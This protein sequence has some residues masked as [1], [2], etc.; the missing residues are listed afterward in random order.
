MSE[1]PPD[2]RTDAADASNGPIRVCHV[3][4]EPDFARMVA[5]NLE[6]ETDRF[7]VEWTTDPDDVVEWVADGAVDCVLTDY[8]MGETTGLELLSSLREIDADL[9]V[10]LFTDTGSETVASDAISAGVSDYLIKGTVAEQYAL[11]ANTIR[12]HVERRRASEAA[13]R[14]SRQL[15]EIADNTSDVLWLFSGDWSELLF[16]NSAY[17][18]VFGQSI[19][20]LSADTSAFLQQVHPEDTADLEAAMTA[21]AAGESR[22]IEYR[23]GGETV[24]WVESVAEPIRNDAG[25]VVRIAGFTR[26]ITDRKQWELDLREK[27]ERLER[28]A[29]MV[30]HDLRNPLSVASGYLDLARNAHDSEHLATVARALGRMERLI[31]DLLAL[32]REGQDVTD[33]TTV[34]L[35]ILVRSSWANVDQQGASLTTATDA[36]V[37]ADEIRL[38][39]LF[40]NLFRN[41]IEHG[42]TAVDDSADGSANA[43]SASS[44]SIRVGRLDDGTGFFVENDGEPIPESHRERIF[45]T[46]FSTN[47][48]GTGFGMAI[49]ER[50]VTA[51]GWTIELA[52]DVTDGVR[53]EIR[54]VEFRS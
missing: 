8:W 35:D 20:T 29:S 17:E 2:P 50:V 10:I 16:A 26:D 46:G 5:T 47:A 42:T 7:S 25:E 53:F 21:T 9:P 48:G 33:M 51:H 32:A 23:L 22:R 13:A 6:A 14:T 12:T 11:L 54:G 18:T 34:D 19:E 31:A 36:T 24:T 27:N 44:L 37:L 41:A 28:F 30:S 39:Q 4:D 1:R 3:D 40:E 45:D 38:G 49:I 52:D 15:H 43:M